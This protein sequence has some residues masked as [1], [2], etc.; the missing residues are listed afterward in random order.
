MQLAA[1]W[2]GIVSMKVATRSP[3]AL[4]TPGLVK[5]EDRKRPAAHDHDDNASPLKRQATS[6]NGTNKSHQDSD[7]PWKDD[8]EV[9]RRLNTGHRKSAQF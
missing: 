6:V 7:I 2:P 3:V 8:L 5:M 9:R 4:K 1:A